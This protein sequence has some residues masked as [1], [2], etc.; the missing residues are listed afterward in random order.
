[1]TCYI[2][3]RKDQLTST[4]KLSEAL[5]GSGKSQ[6]GKKK[7]T[8]P[9]FT[10]DLSPLSLQSKKPAGCSAQTPLSRMVREKNFE[11]FNRQKLAQQS[12]KQHAQKKIDFN[13]FNAPKTTRNATAKATL[14]SKACSSKQASDNNDEIILIDDGDKENIEK[15]DLTVKVDKT[16]FMHNFCRKVI[17]EKEAKMKAQMQNVNNS[18]TSQIVLSVARKIVAENKDVEPK[19]ATSTPVVK[20]TIAT[21]TPL[22]K[23][24]VATSTPVNVN[25][26]NNNAKNPSKKDLIADVNESRM[27]LDF[28]CEYSLVAPLPT[29]EVNENQVN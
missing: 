1:M 24:T 2:K 14:A 29:A 18:N 17:D 16:D 15:M 12:D 10:L 11:I 25:S 6:P 28:D 21:S 4:P 22:A 3:S 23:P 27:Q 26:N 19:I 13:A 7:E 8:A 20:T 9:V 5:I